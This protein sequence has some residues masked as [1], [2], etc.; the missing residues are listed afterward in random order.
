MEKLMP[1]IEQD[2]LMLD[3]DVLAATPAGRLVLNAVIEK[4]LN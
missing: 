3:N 1:L 2:L 4:I